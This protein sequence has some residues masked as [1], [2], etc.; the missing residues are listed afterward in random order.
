MERAKKRMYDLHNAYLENGMHII[1]HK[2]PGIKTV[3]CGLW[4]KQGSCYENDENNGLSHLVEHLL[5]NAEDS[6]NKNYKELMCEVSANGVH[7]NAATT[8]EYTCY[9]FTGLKSNLNLC[10]ECLVNISMF[11][12]TFSD[13]AFEN[14]K[15]VVLQEATEFY[16]SFQ[17]IKERTSQALWGNTGIG[18]VIMG[19]MG[20]ISNAEREETVK[21]ISSSYI[22]DKATVVVVGNIDYLNT[23]DIISEKFGEWKNEK[24][25]HVSDAVE[26]LP[27]IYINNTKANSAVFSIGFRGPAYSDSMRPATE[28]MTRILGQSGM[29]SRMIKEIRLKEG[30]AYNLGSFSSF[31]EKRGTLGFMVTCD[32]N[33]TVDV[34]KRIMNI[35]IK[36]KEGGF[37][38]EEIEREKKMMETAVILSVDQLTDH[39]RQIGR[40]S[41][42]NRNFYIE[43]EIRAI[44]NITKEDVDLAAKETL[45]NELMG[46]AAIGEFNVDKMIEVVSL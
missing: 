13:T 14:E 3:S 31:Y 42:M 30:L 39:L 20:N 6:D 16:S 12:R 15:K 46:L 19:N 37:S 28:M 34:A 43:N 4:I 33:K 26:N 18:R 38:E 5:L 40:C 11:N 27:S 41:V 24:N 25:E 45:K 9:Y 7:Y 17:Q 10:L 29:Y 23:L 8:K 2:I 21:L 44:R 22:P 35:L 36:A 1:M 32:K